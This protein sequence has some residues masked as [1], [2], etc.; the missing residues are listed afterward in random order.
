MRNK[1]L[2]I[3]GKHKDGSLRQTNATGKLCMT[4]MR[5]LPVGHEI[6]R[7]WRTLV[8]GVDDRKPANGA[9]VLHVLGEQGVAAGFD[10]GRDD[11]CIVKCQAVV[12]GKNERC[13]MGVSSVNGNM[14]SKESLKRSRRIRS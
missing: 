9:A 10:R 4:R 5:E 3:F 11:Q 14:A 8:E 12:S 2:L 6:E 7:S 13:R 1:M